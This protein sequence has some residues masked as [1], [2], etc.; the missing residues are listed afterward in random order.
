M[1]WLDLEKI[2]DNSALN[3]RI[4][5]PNG[6]VGSDKDAFHIRSIYWNDIFS[7]YAHMVTGV[8]K[9]YWAINISTNLFTDFVPPGL[10]SDFNIFLTTLAKDVNN[11][12]SGFS[13]SP[14][15]L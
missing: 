13:G 11:T 3:S 8:F 5:Y 2:N 1:K 6:M 4:V 7:F 12:I 14:K 9:F 15:K 10:V